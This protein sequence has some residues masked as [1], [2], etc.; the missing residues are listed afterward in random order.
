MIRRRGATAERPTGEGAGG[1]QRAF[2]LVEL[3]VALAVTTLV[4]A[5]IVPTFV[6]GVGAARQRRDDLEARTLAGAVADTVSRD[7]RQVGRF[8]EGARLVQLRGRRI[9]LVEG[10]DGVRLVRSL[11]PSVEVGETAGTDG[12][13]VSASEQLE[14]EVLVAALG[15]PGRPRGAALP[16]G[17]VESVLEGVGG[18]LVRVGWSR[19]EA[20]LI[21]GWGEPRA[22]VP[23][24]LREYEVVE[25]NGMPMLRRRDAGGYWQP[26]SDG[27]VRLR[28]AVGAEAGGVREV[29]V[30]VEVEPPSGGSGR[31][32]RRVRLPYW[33]AG[34]QP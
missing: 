31:A 29:T 23:I 4:A 18:A 13:W 20:A 14:P 34:L 11:G 5:A 3:L 2:S 17:P 8:L 22:L 6:Q 9:D 27:V 30:T 32:V 7:L 19:P 28:V 10:G 26:V 1:G 12:Y 24:R 33:V 16:V 25:R 21:R 15:Q